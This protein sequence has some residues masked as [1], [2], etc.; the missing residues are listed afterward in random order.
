MLFTGSKRNKLSEREEEIC[1]LIAFVKTS[2]WAPE[3]YDAVIDGEVVAYLRLRQGVFEV[4]DE[5]LGSVWFRAE[6]APLT[7]EFPPQSREFFM[8]EARKAIAKNLAAKEMLPL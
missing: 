4:S 1:K 2:L 3:Q 8:E 6:F 5:P 7:N